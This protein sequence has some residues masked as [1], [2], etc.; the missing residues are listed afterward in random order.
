MIVTMCKEPQ[1]E[2]VNRRPLFKM[3]FLAK[4]GVRKFVE[5]EKDNKLYRG[6]VNTAGSKEGLGVEI[7]PGE[8]IYEGEFSKDAPN[9]LGRFIYVSGR[10]YVGNFQNGQP[11]GKGTV[12]SPEGIALL[13]NREKAQPSIWKRITEVIPQIK[14]LTN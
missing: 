13:A 8:W 14:L 1:I 7:K 10:T 5:F 9:G 4:K 3:P 12:Y 2:V 11:H 6:E